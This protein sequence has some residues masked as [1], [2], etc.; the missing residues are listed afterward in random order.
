V[1]WV[2]YLKHPAGAT[3]LTFTISSATGSRQVVVR[4]AVGP[5]DPRWVELANSE[6]V[7][8]FVKLGF[9]IPGSY[10]MTY[11]HGGTVLAQGTFEL[12]G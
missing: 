5:V 3:S 10:T 6:P 12:E 2:A 1:A 4:H 11:A 9:A 8:G 7:R